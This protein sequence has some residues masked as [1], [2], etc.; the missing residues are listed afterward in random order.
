M[1]LFGLI[2]FQ[3]DSPVTA[4]EWTSERENSYYEMCNKLA[5]DYKLDLIIDQDTV[6]IVRNNEKTELVKPN[7]HKTFWF[8]TWLR[9]KAYLG[10][11]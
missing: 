11:D 4:S 10:L 2:R 9:L 8:E 6:Y 7:R 1:A 5:Y 3:K